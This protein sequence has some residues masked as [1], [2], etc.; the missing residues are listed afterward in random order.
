MYLIKNNWGKTENCTGFSTLVWEESHVVALLLEWVVLWRK[1]CTTDCCVYPDHFRGHKSQ[2]H[3]CEDVQ[4]A[5]YPEKTVKLNIRISWNSSDWILDCSSS[6]MNNDGN[7]RPAV[8]S[9]RNKH[10][11][12]CCHRCQTKLWP[13]L[14]KPKRLSSC[15][16]PELHL[17]GLMAGA[18]VDTH[19]LCSLKIQK[20][21][22]F[23][24]KLCRIHIV[25]QVVKMTWPVC[26]RPHVMLA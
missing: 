7:Q 14:A 15:P 6:E 11:A 3:F 22:F 17:S 1:S 16:W 19:L 24:C 4:L 23:A 9:P 20:L 2:D 10:T 26:A 8:R 12:Q 13:N 18:A 21:T 5:A 25:R